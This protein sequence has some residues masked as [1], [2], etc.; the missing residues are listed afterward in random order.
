MR[1]AAEKRGPARLRLAK[2]PLLLRK[3]PVDILLEA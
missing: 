1:T 3:R 2:F